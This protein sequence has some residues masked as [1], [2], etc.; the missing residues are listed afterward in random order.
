ML[1]ANGEMYVVGE[2]GTRTQPDI[3]R[4]DTD[5]LLCFVLF[6]RTR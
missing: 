4:S 2:V 6:C 5:T 1:K 3:S